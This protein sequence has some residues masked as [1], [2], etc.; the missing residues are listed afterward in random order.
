MCAKNNEKIQP[1]CNFFGC[2]VGKIIV[3]LRVPVKQ[4]KLRLSRNNT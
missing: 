4:N 3:I 2:T 1:L